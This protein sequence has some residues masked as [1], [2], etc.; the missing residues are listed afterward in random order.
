MTKRDLKMIKLRKYFVTNGVVKARVWYSVASRIDNRKCVTIYAKD[1]DRKLGKIFSDIYKNETDTMTD[2][3]D[4]GH[5]NLFEDHPLYNEALK[6][7][8]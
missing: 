6:L 3:F 5:V 7:A 4:Q 2:Y 1:Y 8:A